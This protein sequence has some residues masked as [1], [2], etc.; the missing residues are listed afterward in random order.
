MK[1]VGSPQRYEV[2]VLD[3]DKNHFAEFT[4]A[5]RAAHLVASLLDHLTTGDKIIIDVKDVEAPKGHAA[6]STPD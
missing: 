3:G 4:D 5:R 1:I 2:L 6:A